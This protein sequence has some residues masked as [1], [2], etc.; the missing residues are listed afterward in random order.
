[1]TRAQVRRTSMVVFI[2]LF[3]VSLYMNY[4]YFRKHQRTQEWRHFSYNWFVTGVV[5]G[6]YNLGYGGTPHRDPK[7]AAVS[8]GE[9]AMALEQMAAYTDITH[10][11][12]TPE[13]RD[14]NSFQSPPH[15]ED[16]E[17]Y[18]SY[19]SAI[20]VNPNGA[21]HS[22][23]VADAEKYVVEITKLLFKEASQNGV[24][25][26]IPDSKADTIFNQMYNLIPNSI[27]QQNPGGPDERFSLP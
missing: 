20:M 23:D 4:L 22:G 19:A 6:A 13:M 10:T 26:D 3:I 17:H 5:Q 15:I 27:I 21:F 11:Q 16:V 9:A 1:M 12:T 2:L 14:Q 7:R 8:V 18:L 24:L 25:S